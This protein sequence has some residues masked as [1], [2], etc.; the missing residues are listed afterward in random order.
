M[1]PLGVGVYGPFKRYFNTACDSFYDF[2]ELSGHAF[3]KA[4]SHC[5][6]TLSFKATGI[7]P[8]NIFP[9]DAFLSEAVTD[10]CVDVNTSA[11]EPAPSTS[12]GSP[13]VSTS[14][15]SP[16]A[17]TRKESPHP[18]HN[19]VVMSYTGKNS[20]SLHQLSVG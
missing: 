12:Q 16:A 14:Q 13:A 20:R 5:N 7:Y 8:R 17:S 9:D 18:Q 10:R 19:Y 2:A 6:T 11:T 3:D 1:Q 15:G 4:F